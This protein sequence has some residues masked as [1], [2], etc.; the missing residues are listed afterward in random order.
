ML[1]MIIPKQ[2]NGSKKQEK[3]EK[4]AALTNGNRCEQVWVGEE[5]LQPHFQ[6]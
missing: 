2:K 3:R 5:F 6:G 1:E 4:F